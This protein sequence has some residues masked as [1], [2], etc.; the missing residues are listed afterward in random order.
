MLNIIKKNFQP[1][2]IK[3]FKN[4]LIIGCSYHKY[5]NEK[6]NIETKLLADEIAKHGINPILTDLKWPRDELF[7]YNNGEYDYVQS[8][9]IQPE[10]WNHEAYHGGMYLKGDNFI[11]GSDSMNLEKREK[12]ERL[13]DA[14][15]GFY[16]PGREMNEI[17]LQ[18][19]QVIYKS[20]HIDLVVGITN[21]NKTI[22]TYEHLELMKIVKEIACETDYNFKTIPLQEAKYGAINFLEL[23]NHIVIDRRAKKTKK[24]LKNLGYKIIKSPKPMIETNKHGGGIRC[25]TNEMPKFYDKLIFYNEKNKEKFY[26]FEIE[27]STAMFRNLKG[28]G[29]IIQDYRDKKFGPYLYA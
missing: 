19:D 21:L 6:Q 16:L 25:I 7:F 27:Q 18:E 4:D 12:T 22:F 5:P 2:Q 28:E 23:G 8:G 11:I 13:L 24:I 29:V 3:N 1:T 20:S 26:N 14:K 10:Y 17:L 9:T 15:K